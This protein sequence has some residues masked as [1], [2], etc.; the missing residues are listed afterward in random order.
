MQQGY[1]PCSVCGHYGGEWVEVD[2]QSRS[3]TAPY[4]VTVE[5]GEEWTCKLCVE[6]GHEQKASI[7]EDASKN[8]FEVGDS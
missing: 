6:R 2:G 5:E 4:N 8:L 7:D 3:I 1:K